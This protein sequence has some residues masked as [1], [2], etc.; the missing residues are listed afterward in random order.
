MAAMAKAMHLYQISNYVEARD[1]FNQVIIL[2]PS[3]LHPSLALAEVNLKL[4]CFDEAERAALRAEQLLKPD[5]P[6]DLK[7]KTKLTLIEAVVRNPISKQLKTA[8]KKLE[9]V[10]LF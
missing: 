1:A 2:K 8:V 4:Y 7:L 10:S 6:V 9:D 3:W 5:T